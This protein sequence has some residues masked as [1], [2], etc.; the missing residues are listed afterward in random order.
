MRGREMM[1]SIEQSDIALLSLFYW[2]LSVLMIRVVIEEDEQGR[3]RLYALSILYMIVCS[4]I[5]W[6]VQMK[7]VLAGSLLFMVTSMF[8][9]L[10][11]IL[12]QSRECMADLKA[13]LEEEKHSYSNKE[14]RYR[15]E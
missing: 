5:G 2:V 10:W 13:I 4:L 11:R 15:G 6:Y 14:E 7:W 8:Y 12:A 3:N 9:T 1:M